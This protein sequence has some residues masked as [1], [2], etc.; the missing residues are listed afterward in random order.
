M[1]SSIIAK[2]LAIVTIISETRTPITFSELVVQ[3]G[4]NKSTLHRVLGI[5][6]QERLVQYDKSLKV[7]LLGT[8]VFDLVRD[9]YSGYDIQAV[10]LPKMAMS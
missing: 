6:V 8:K 9:A 1:Q 2:L 4:L 3:S 10:A 7:Y 5:A